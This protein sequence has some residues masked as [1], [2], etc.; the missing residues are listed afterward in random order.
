MLFKAGREVANTI[1]QSLSHKD[2]VTMWNQHWIHRQFHKFCFLLWFCS[3]SFLQIFVICKSILVMVIILLLFIFWTSVS[4]QFVIDLVHGDHQKILFVA[5]LY[6]SLHLSVWGRGRG[7]NL[8]SYT[9]SSKEMQKY[10][11]ICKSIE[12]KTKIDRQK[13]NCSNYCLW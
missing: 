13:R 6:L 1:H 12:I 8:E 7:F 11:Q 3:S 5:F 2:L 10:R 4:I 9:M